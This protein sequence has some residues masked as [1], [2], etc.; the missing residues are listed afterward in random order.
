MLLDNISLKI[1]NVE[2]NFISNDGVYLIVESLKENCSLEQLRVDNQRS[3]YKL[4]CF[5]FLFVFVFRIVH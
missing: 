4:C 1:L 5:C 3:R 2:S